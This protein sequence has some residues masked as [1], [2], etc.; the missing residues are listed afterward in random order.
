MLPLVMLLSNLYSL[1]SQLSILKVLSVTAIWVAAIERV[2]LLLVYVDSTLG[3][4]LLKFIDKQ[5]LRVRTW[6]FIKNQKILYGLVIERFSCSCSND[7]QNLEVQN[8]QQ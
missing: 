4:L 8:K 3:Y 1:T 7:N 2:D 5:I 6:L